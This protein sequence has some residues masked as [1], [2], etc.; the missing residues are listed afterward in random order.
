MVALLGAGGSVLFA[1]VEG[2]RLILADFGAVVLP[3][4]GLGLVVATCGWVELV[5]PR[6]G[7]VSDGSVELARIR[8]AD[9]AAL[10][11]LLADVFATPRVDVVYARD[12][13]WVDGRGRSFDLDAD[14]RPVTLVRQEGEPIAAVLH[15]ADVPLE[16]IEL[17]AR[18]TGAQL[19]AQRAA[20]LAASRADAVRAATG[21][22]VRA[23]DR[24]AT[25][26][27]A[28]LG[29]GPIATLDSLARGL[30]RGGCTPAD[31]ATTLRR[32]TAEVRE[33]SHGLFPRELEER[34][35]SGVLHNPGTPTRRLTAAAEMTCYLLAHDDAAAVFADRQDCIEVDRSVVLTVEMVERVEALGGTATGTV[36]RVPVE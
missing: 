14:R 34:G 8:P 19:Q 17:G 11:S 4:L 29:S 3:V 15:D 25:R 2:A 13:G 31:A 9:D 6:L 24:A 27:E 30:H 22:L 12:A 10:Q 18:V 1:R 26:I 16:A 32:V 28:E 35:L 7:R 23:G 33:F 20:A 36:A 5:R 21:R